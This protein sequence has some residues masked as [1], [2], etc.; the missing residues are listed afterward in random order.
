METLIKRQKDIIKS[1]ENEYLKGSCNKK[2]N[3][4]VVLNPFG[5]CP[6]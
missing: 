4:Y 2:I 6:L 5:K 1:M 3:P